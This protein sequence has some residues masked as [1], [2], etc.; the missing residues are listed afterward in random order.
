[1]IVRF[2]LIS[3]LYCVNLRKR[4]NPQLF[5]FLVM[6]IQNKNGSDYRSKGYKELQV[7]IRT[8]RSKLPVAVF[9]KESSRKERR[10]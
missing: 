7:E 5:Q 10:P 2:Q 4:R 1:M 8:I 9:R 6:Q 3:G